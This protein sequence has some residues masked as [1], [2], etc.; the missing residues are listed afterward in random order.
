M[1]LFRFVLPEYMSKQRNEMSSIEPGEIKINEETVPKEETQTENDQIDESIINLYVEETKLNENNTIKQTDLIKEDEIETKITEI[2]RTKYFTEKDLKKAQDE[3]KIANR[4]FQRCNFLEKAINTYKFIDDPTKLCAALLQKEIKSGHKERMC[5][6]T[7]YRMLSYLC[8]KKR[9]RLWRIQFKFKEKIRAL[10][11]ITSNDTDSAYPRFETY[12]KQM[13]NRFILSIHMEKVRRGVIPIKPSVKK[14]TII[15][16]A[17]IANSKITSTSKTN[18]GITPKFVRLRTLHEF[19]FYLVYENCITPETPSDE[20]VIDKKQ[21]IQHW[22]INEPHLIDFDELNDLPAIYSTNI[23]WKMFVPP[24]PKHSEYPHGWFLVSDILCR[25]PLSIFIRVVN[26]TYEIRGLDDVLSHP[27]KKHLL[28]HKLPGEIQQALFHRRKYLFN[29]EELLKRFCC[30]GIAQTG[31]KKF[32]IIDQRFYFLNRRATLLNTI[33]SRPG[34]IRTSIQDYTEQFYEFNSYKYVQTYWDDMYKICMS[35]KLNRRSASD[36]KQLIY[37]VANEKL[38][39]NSCVIVQPDEAIKKDIGF[40]PGDRRGAAGLD[41]TMFAHLERNWSFTTNIF[42]PPPKLRCNYGT[43][44]RYKKVRV[45]RDTT[46]RDGRKMT[47]KLA[48]ASIRRRQSISRRTIKK[49]KNVYDDVDKAAIATMSS[50]RVE[51]NAKEDNF[52][53]LCRL[54]QLYLSGNGRP[55]PSTVIRDLV[56]W[57]CKSFDKTSRACARRVLY[58]MKKLGNSRQINNNVFSCLGEI[59]END[60]IHRRFGNLTVK[61]KKLYPHESDFMDAFK[62]HYID[63]VYL[64]TS[65]YYNLKK[66][67][68]TTIL[69]IPNTLIEFYEKYK[70]KS[71]IYDMNTL[72]FDVPETKTDIEIMTIINLIHSTMCCNFDKTSWSIQLYEIYKDFTERQLSIAMQKV[73]SEQLISINK[74]FNRYNEKGKSRSLPLTATS[75]HLSITY[76]QQLFTRIA[77]ELFDGS[78]QRLQEIVDYVVDQHKIYDFNLWNSTSCFLFAELSHKSL[79]HIDIDVPKNI[80]IFDKSQH[81]VNETYEKMFERVNECDYVDL[82]E[83]VAQQ[84]NV[85]ESN[86]ADDIATTL[87]T[88]LSNLP[89]ES[90]HLMCIVNAYGKIFSSNECKINENGECTIDCL[91]QKENSPIENAVKSLIE[92]REIY[93]RISADEQR[94]L[95][96]LP[97]EITIAETNMLLIFGHLISKSTTFDVKKRNYTDVFKQMLEIIDETLANN[98]KRN[99]SSLLGQ[100]LDFDEYY[101]AKANKNP[102]RE[103][104]ITDKQHIFHDF[105]YVKTCKISLE[106][107]HNNNDA[108]NIE[109]LIDN[110]ETVMENIVK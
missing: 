48:T 69:K 56:H 57:H 34:Y 101:D 36:G 37:K 58:I 6:K 20:Q 95:G 61:L 32:N 4:I 84:E 50:S 71:D 76:Q 47:Y 12:I 15:S 107:K 99:V 73:R 60:A 28:L 105:L 87:Q 78:F 92:K 17:I 24:L 100:D 42:K 38:M 8:V 91:K 97:E 25:M 77:Y 22:K 72:R 66:S 51:W 75:Y 68:E 33:T 46:R 106:P 44:V 53:L 23:E 16:P 7:Y 9:I 64:L 5:K 90:Y 18:Y 55:I 81:V 110:R 70:I 31:A 2:F 104:D 93:G 52:L 74:L 62:I 40:L 96:L 39:N 10:T 94:R 59:K 63:L 11:S 21:A 49:K 67:I 1:F 108:L 45:A 79:F 26:F 35:T 88:K 19:L 14:P 54:A 98:E 83:S 41:T 29:F 102:S 85:T 109:E 43:A 80:L 89:P 82:D 30:M 103:I 13:K 27:I 86:A 3:V 65:Q